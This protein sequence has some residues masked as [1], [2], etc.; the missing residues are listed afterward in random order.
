MNNNP[1]I[2]YVFDLDIL[3]D[4]DTLR[5]GNS[6]AFLYQLIYFLSIGVHKP[7]MF[8]RTATRLL[9]QN[10]II[11]VDILSHQCI[12]GIFRGGDGGDQDFIE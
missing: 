2:G 6:H 8:Y 3:A 5:V 4:F 7:S 9:D 11:L 1:I 10:N 12:D